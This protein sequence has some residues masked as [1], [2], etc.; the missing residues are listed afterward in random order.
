MRKKGNEKQTPNEINSLARD[1]ERDRKWTRVKRILLHFF[2][3]CFFHM[4]CEHLA[5]N[6]MVA[7]K[8]QHTARYAKRKKHPIFACDA[9]FIIFSFCF[10]LLPLLFCS[11]SVIFFSLHVSSLLWFVCVVIL[12][13]CFM[14]QLLR[15]GAH[16]AMTQSLWPTWIITI[17]FDNVFHDSYFHSQP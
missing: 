5:S 4:V 17:V 10:C 2:F 11:I 6:E 1:D 3:V 14:F 13:W 16:S 9:T 15:C 7:Y 8:R 12:Q